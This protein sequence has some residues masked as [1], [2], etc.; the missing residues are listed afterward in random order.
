MRFSI[1]IPV[2]NSGQYLRNCLDS[3]LRQTYSDFEAICIDDYSVDDTIS[4]IEEYKKND[5]RFILIQDKNNSYGHKLNVGFN[6]SKGEYVCILE[7]DDMFTDDALESFE[8]VINIY[9]PDYVDGDY[10]EFLTFGKFS[11]FKYIKKYNSTELYDCL[12]I[13]DKNYDAFSFVT[14]SIWTGAYKKDFIKR[15][16]ILFNESPGASYQ[17]ISFRFLTIAL[18]RTSYHIGKLVYKYRTDNTM[19]SVKDYSKA[20]AIHDEYNYLYNQ[21]KEKNLMKIKGMNENFILWKYNSYCWNLKRL[22]EVNAKLFA[23]HILKE[24]NSDLYYLRIIWEQLP[25]EILELY[26]NTDSF[27]KELTDKEKIEYEIQHK[28]DSI[29]L[30]MQER[31]VIFGCGKIGQKLYLDYASD[32]NLIVAFCDNDPLKQGTTFWGVP[33][34]SLVE[35]LNKFPNIQYIIANK[36]STDEI[37]DQLITYGVS[38]NNIYIYKEQI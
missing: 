38:K 2:H 1:I 25:I 27:I 17:D 11:F 15:T 29:R 20:F 22:N 37:L 18:A 24:F 12:T 32:R 16:K 5:S 34:Y 13:A 23:D 36:K 28:P 9:H 8:A 14:F 33:I 6:N 31:S 3:L 19:S 7:S 21:L 10:Q 4:I 30:A 35:T 26:N